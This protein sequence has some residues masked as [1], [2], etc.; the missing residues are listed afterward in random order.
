M[1]RA[2][3]V[4]R[5]SDTTAVPTDVSLAPA[6]P[7]DEAPREASRGRFPVGLRFMA[8][9][10]LFFSAMSMLVKVASERGIPA[11][12]IV[13]VR[14]A[15]MTLL[16]AGLARAAGV[17]LG[18]VD[19]RRLL[20]RGLAG[21]TALS[22]FY[23]ALGRLPLGDATA[24]HY[25][26][27]IWTAAL[28]AQLL[29]ERPGRSLLIALALSGAGVVLITRP[30][31]VFGGAALDTLGVAAALAGATLSGLA[32]VSVRQLRKTDH[33]LTVVFWLSWL[34][35]TVA[36]PFAIAGWV[37]LRP[38]DWLILVAVGLTTQVAQV[39]MTRGL[40]LETAGRAVAVGYL[41]VVF[42][43]GW[44]FLVFGTRPTAMGLL[45]AALVV[46]STLA[47]ARRKDDDLTSRGRRH[48]S[49]AVSSQTR[50]E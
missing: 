26:A 2:D 23:Y 48:R 50:S 15:V 44:G 18:G 8:G 38:A 4:P 49:D 33:P 7:V 40:H 12:E 41:Q 25:T 45:G 36:L 46:A 9:S 47:L 29:D 6:L 16:T 22:L 43:F 28:A 31:I 39:M 35:V 37:P 1:R 24:L 14:C 17:S 20:S 11:M 3:Q 30:A 27:P 21:A 34:G 19:R 42:A 5:L 13:L 10:A 32:Y